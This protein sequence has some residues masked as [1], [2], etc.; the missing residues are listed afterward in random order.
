MENLFKSGIKGSR[1]WFTKIDRS[2]Q[3]PLPYREEIDSDTNLEKF[4]PALTGYT[5]LRLFI[6]P[7]STIK[8]YVYGNLDFSDKIW[9]ERCAY[10]ECPSDEESYAAINN[11][12]KEIHGRDIGWEHP[13]LKAVKEGN[14]E[15]VKDILERG[16]DVNIKDEMGCTALIKASEF[17]HE[18]IAKL[19]IEKGADVNAREDAAGCTALM[20]AAFWRYKEIVKLLVEKRADVNAVDANDCTALMLASNWRQNKDIINLLIKTGADVNARDNEGWTLLMRVAYYSGDEEIINLL[21]KMGAD[22]NARSNHGWAA[23]DAA[24]AKRHL[25]AVKLLEKYS[26]K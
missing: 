25:D 9:M 5:N 10:F 20:L 4:L 14:L 23:L 12:F 16:E 26:K 6:K 1:H 11:I 17:G 3:S 15:G 19:L 13:L 24:T 21:I 8:F 7:L 22:V 2:P 18:E